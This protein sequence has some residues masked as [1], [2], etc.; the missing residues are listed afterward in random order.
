MKSPVFLSLLLSF[1]IINQSISQNLE[2]IDSLEKVVRTPNPDSLKA[3][4]YFGLTWQHLLYDLQ[5]SKHYATQGLNL[6][7]KM[8]DS[9]GIHRVY[10]YWGLIHRLESNYDSSLYYFQKVIDFHLRNGRESNTLQARFNMGVVTSFQGLYEKSLEH[11]LKALKIA[12]DVDD[13]YMVADVLNSMG[14]IH[15]KLK[16]Y[17][18]SLEMTHTA[19]QI[20]EEQ[21]N[22]NQQANCL[23]NIGSLYA[24]TLEFDSALMYFQKAYEIDKIQNVAWGIAH[25]LT[26]IGEVYTE[27]GDYALASDFLLEGLTIRKELGQRKEIAESYLKLAFLNNLQNKALEAQQYAQQAIALSAEIGDRPTLRDAY[28]MLAL[29]YE[30]MGNYRLAYQHHLSY[31][32]L[33]DSMLNESNTRQINTLQAQYETEKKEKEI[34]LLSR[35]KEIQQATIVQKDTEIKALTVVF[36]LAFLF[37]LTLIFFF[38]AKIKNQKLITLKNEELHQRRVDQL[39]KQQKIISMEAMVAGQEE[40]RKRIAKDLHD[41]LGNL[42]A[43]VQMQFST[44]QD[45]IRQERLGSYQE[46]NQLLGEA[47]GEVRKIAHNMMPGTLTKFGLVSAILDMKNTIEKT[48]KISVDVQVYGIKKRLEEKVEINLYRIIQELMN[49]IIK[50]AQATEV[51]I[52]LTQQGEDLNLLVEDNGI[53]FDLQQAQKKGG[54]GMKSLQSRVSYVDGTLEIDT[55]PGRGT[56]VLIYVPIVQKEKEVLLHT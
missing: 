48:K 17:G 50:H 7:K 44:V 56:S 20:A 38:R 51:M 5:K 52:Q 39:E 33:H 55:V 24:E 40:E 4:A 26:N 12:E 37:I 1:I 42:L 3:K 8:G 41:G 54:L 28:K 11:Y 16:N 30:H 27:K 23:S 32:V 21:E 19:L 15:K 22:L 2:L 18:Q 47:C 25:Q 9:L 53:G 36:V 14:I 6:S 31:T 34:V 49:N 43:N 46:A 13:Q 10:H 45:H 35:D 29:A